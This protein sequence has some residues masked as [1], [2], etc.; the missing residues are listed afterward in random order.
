MR[1]FVDGW[2]GKAEAD[3]WADPIVATCPQQS[4]CDDCGVFTCSFAQ[5]MAMECPTITPSQIPHFRKLMC[6]EL[7]EFLVEL[8]GTGKKKRT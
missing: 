7:K 1:K 4:N 3:A 6:L 5:S 8:E 2:I